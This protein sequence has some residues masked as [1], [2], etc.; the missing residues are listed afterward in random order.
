VAKIDKYGK[1]MLTKE[2]VLPP[3]AQFARVLELSQKPKYLVVRPALDLGL[4]LMMRSC[5]ISKLRWEV[6]G[7]H[8]IQISRD[9][10]KYGK[11][12]NIHR[13][14]HLTRVFNSLHEIVKTPGRWCPRAG[15]YQ[16][17]RPFSRC[18][19][20]KAFSFYVVG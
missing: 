3:L 11:P 8:V 4:G 20:K 5:E 16:R 2:V 15:A 17:R 10:G 6:V 7:K 1:K 19:L 18:G 9:L 13:S 12:R 14:P